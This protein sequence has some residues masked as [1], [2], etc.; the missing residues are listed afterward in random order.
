MAVTSLALQLICLSRT[1]PIIIYS[2]SRFGL[3]A[4]GFSTITN[5]ELALDIQIILTDSENKESAV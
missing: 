5:L 2:K 1:N 3:A 4:T